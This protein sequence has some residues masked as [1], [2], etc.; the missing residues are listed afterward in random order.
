MREKLLLELTGFKETQV[1]SLQLSRCA[2]AR[3]E[4]E[5]VLVFH[6]VTLLF[7]C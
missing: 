5:F 4:P 2:R 3:G 6:A 1:G 7:S